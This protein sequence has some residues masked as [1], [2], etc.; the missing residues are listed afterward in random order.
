[1]SNDT[2]ETGDDPLPL[3]PVDC[4][5]AEQWDRALSRKELPPP[6]PPAAAPKWQF[7]MIDLFV[8]TIGCSL[9]MA[10]GTWMP[11]SVYA[12]C[13][14]ITI[15]LGMVLIP[16]LSQLPELLMRWVWLALL[17]AYAASIAAVAMR[18]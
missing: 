11:V 2:S 4:P 15:L 1:M 17:S 7:S 8:L 9:G 14:G 6:E 3:K 18:S 5:S 10:G 12:A 13:L 16:F